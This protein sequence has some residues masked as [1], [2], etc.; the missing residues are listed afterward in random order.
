MFLFSL[1]G[2]GGWES[3]GSGPNSGGGCGHILWSH[4]PKKVHAQLYGEGQLLIVRHEPATPDIGQTH[5]TGSL[6]IIYA[7]NFSN[8]LPLKSSKRSVSS[9]HVRRV[10]YCSFFLFNIASRVTANCAQHWLAI[11]SGKTSPGKKVSHNCSIAISV[12][13]LH[14]PGP[15][16]VALWD[17]GLISPGQV[18]YQSHRRET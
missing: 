10:M 2:I 16:T 15:Q 18:G 8:T 11:V 1:V 9:S 17:F 13:F 12:S 4:R 5:C 14:S 3:S 6:V 7:H